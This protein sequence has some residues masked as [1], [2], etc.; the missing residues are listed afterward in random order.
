[1]R[2]E[3]KKLLT[4]KEFS[5]LTGIEESTLRYWDRIGL[6]RPALRHEENNYRLY[7]LEQV[8]SINF[9]TVMSSL[10]LPLKTIGQA[11][12][13]RAPGIIIPLLE[14][15]ELEIDKEL[16]QAKQPTTQ[17]YEPHA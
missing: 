3:Q 16:A 17:G 15:Q 9:I 8:V 14:Q 11:R 10:K 5:E 12:D 6:F 13:T 7:T 1:M 2:S 4:I